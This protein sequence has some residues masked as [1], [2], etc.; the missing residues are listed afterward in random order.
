[1]THPILEKLSTNTI[2]LKLQDLW[3]AKPWYLVDIIRVL[4]FRRSAGSPLSGSSSPRLLDLED[5]L[6]TAHKTY[7]PKEW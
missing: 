6:F 3:D 7:I 2:Y 4:A 5:N 1:M